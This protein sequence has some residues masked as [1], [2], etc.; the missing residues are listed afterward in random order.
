MFENVSVEVES[1]LTSNTVQRQRTN[2]TGDTSVDP[3]G[4]SVTGLGVSSV[5]FNPKHLVTVHALSDPY[6]R[7]LHSTTGDSRWRVT[8]Y[9]LS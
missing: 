7:Q 3:T 6:L 1:S 5:L 4:E 8:K 9:Y 2:E